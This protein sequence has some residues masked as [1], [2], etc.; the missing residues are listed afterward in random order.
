MYYN[1]DP[2]ESYS[3]SL[4]FLLDVQ[5]VEYVLPGSSVEI[6]VR[7][8]AKTKWLYTDQ[9]VTRFA[10]SLP[11]WLPGYQARLPGSLLDY[12]FSD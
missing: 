6:G 2:I 7:D 10:D 9:R 12:K 11:G 8:P 3:L 5:N 4:V 1:S